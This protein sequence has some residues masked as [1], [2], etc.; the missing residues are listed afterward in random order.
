MAV[1]VSAH[2]LRS[3]AISFWVEEGESLP[4]RRS[5]HG[6]FGYREEAAITGEP[7]PFSKIPGD[8]VKSGSRVIHGSF[9]VRAEKVGGDSII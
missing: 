7:K 3:D 1:Y 9:K 5:N 6:R 4:G 8:W 2:Y